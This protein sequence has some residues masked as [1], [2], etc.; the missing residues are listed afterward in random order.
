MNRCRAQRQMI[1][2]PVAIEALQSVRN[3]FVM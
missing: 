1:G 2:L 3:G